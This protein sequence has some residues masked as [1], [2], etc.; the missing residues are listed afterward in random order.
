MSATASLVSTDADSGWLARVLVVE[1]DTDLAEVVRASLVD[2][3]FDVTVALDGETALGLLASEKFDV[4]L[5]DLML[6]GVDGYEVCTWLRSARPGVALLILTALGTHDSILRGLATGADDYLVKPF[7]LSE[8]V[9]RIRAVLRRGSAA[10]I[11]ANERAEATGPD[12]ILQVSGIR[13]DQATDRVTYCGVDL[14]LGPRQKDMLRA[15]LSMPGLVLTRR[16]IRGAMSNPDSIM[17][18]TS[19]DYHLSQLRKK[20]EAA[21]GAGTIETVFGLGWRLLVAD[22]H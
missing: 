2:E 20:L 15:F 1:D 21:G 22:D 6:P 16:T 10:R 14:D 8:L 19:I 17:S 12:A 7:G 11:K 5:V 13:F 4:A 3:F 18:D 9:A